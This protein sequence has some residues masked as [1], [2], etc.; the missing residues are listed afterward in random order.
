MQSF[1]L[2]GGQHLPVG[3]KVMEHEFFHQK[4]GMRLS[5]GQGVTQVKCH[6][7]YALKMEVD[8]SKIKTPIKPNYYGH[9]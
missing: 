2:F 9:P 7:Q 4:E 5:C 3:G 8:G 1:K 6:T